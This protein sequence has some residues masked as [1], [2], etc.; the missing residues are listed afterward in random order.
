MNWN[1][2][3]ELGRRF[4]GCYM[5]NVSSASS[6]SWNRGSTKLLPFLFAI[7]WRSLED[8]ITSVGPESPFFISILQSLVHTYL[9]CIFLAISFV[10]WNRCCLEGV[11]CSCTYNFPFHVS[12]AFAALTHLSLVLVLQSL[13]TIGRGAFLFLDG[14]R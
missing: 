2:E 8:L 7:S 13:T 9:Y 4:C 6:W 14:T 12:A 10:W 5:L 11:K 1:E 3:L